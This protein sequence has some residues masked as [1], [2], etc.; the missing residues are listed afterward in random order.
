MMIA[1]VANE[2]GIASISSCRRSEADSIAVL[3]PQIGFPGTK[4]I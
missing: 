3:Q 2:I 1:I 4:V